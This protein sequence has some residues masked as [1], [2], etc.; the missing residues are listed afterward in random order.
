VKNKVLIAGVKQ[1]IVAQTESLLKAIAMGDF[2]LYKWVEL[3]VKCCL[4]YKL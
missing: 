3:P 1:E 4:P 2:E